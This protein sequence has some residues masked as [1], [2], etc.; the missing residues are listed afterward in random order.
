MSLHGGGST[1]L[2]QIDWWAGSQLPNGSRFGQA[3]RRGYIVIAPAW[4]KTQQ[5]TYGYSAEEHAAVLNSLRD[6][7]RRFSIDTDR[8]FLSG[9]SMGGD[10]AWDIALAHPDQW[11]GVIPIA[12]VADKYVS[13]YWENAAYMPFYLVS[14]QL[15]GE[16][17]VR[18]S[19]ELDRYF[20]HG[21]NTTVV[22]FQG[23]GHEHFSDEILRIFDWMG[24]NHRDFF[25]KEFVTRSMRDWDNSFWW[26]ELQDLPEKAVVAPE[27]WPPP[28][29]LLPVLTKASVKEKNTIFVNTGA[30][31]AVVWLSPELVDL[32]QPVRLTVNGV[33]LKSTPIIEPDLTVLL[34]DVRTRGDRQRVFWAKVEMP[35]GRVNSESR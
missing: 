10:A 1:P 31:R 3:T 35:A 33:R 14:G 22:E 13:R 7:C 9:H 32:K 8:V 11:A 4:T 18:N 19:T 24:R 17:P 16:Y 2:T 20:K 30:G 29:G 6:A 15:D 23:R 25:P 5:R 28:A 26:L 27:N 12:A 34:E 21:Y